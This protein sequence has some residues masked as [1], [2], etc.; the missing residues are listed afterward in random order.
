MAWDNVA[1]QRLYQRAKAANT[2]LDLRPCQRIV[3]YTFKY[4]AAA[5]KKAEGSTQ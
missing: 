4:A 3:D 5:K 1:R 2:V